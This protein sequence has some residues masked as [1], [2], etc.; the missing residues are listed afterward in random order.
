MPI[1]D[2]VSSKSVWGK[3]GGMEKSQEFG[4]PMVMVPIYT[5]VYYTNSCILAAR[6]PDKKRRFAPFL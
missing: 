4:F 2:A 6:S 3:G 1:A 5:Y